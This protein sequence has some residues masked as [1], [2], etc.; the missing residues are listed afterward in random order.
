MFSIPM[1]SRTDEIKAD[2]D[3]CIMKTGE[4]TLNLQLFL[5][6][7]FKLGINIVN[8]RFERFFFVDLIPISN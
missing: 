8:D 5:E 7:G 1:A 2:M 3:A 4:L 6:V